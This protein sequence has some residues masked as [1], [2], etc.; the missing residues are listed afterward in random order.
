LEFLPLCPQVRKTQQTL[1]A[2][3]KL[4]NP[5]PAS[6][7]NIFADQTLFYFDAKPT[8]CSVCH[9]IRGNGIG[10]L[11]H[12]LAPSPRNFTYSQTID[13]LPDRQLFWIIRN[14]SPRKAMPTFKI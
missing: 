9:G 3:L 8:P 1:D 5:L 6:P 13:L 12:E 2:Y 10:L 7:E 14:G 11:F 4:K